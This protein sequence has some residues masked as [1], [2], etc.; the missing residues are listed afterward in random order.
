MELLLIGFVIGFI[1]SKISDKFIIDMKDN[2]FKFILVWGVILF[3]HLC[4]GLILKNYFLYSI[5]LYIIV[6]CCK[7]FFLNR[8][9]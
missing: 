7:I 6:L 4:I 9:K 3:L 1:D 5:Y 8:S 2:I